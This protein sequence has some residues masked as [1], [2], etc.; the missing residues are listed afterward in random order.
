VIYFPLFFFQLSLLPSFLLTMDPLPITLQDLIESTDALDLDCP[1]LATIAEAP[2]PQRGAFSL[3]GQLI[4]S[5]PLNPLTVW[6]TLQH[7]WKFALPLSFA[8]VGHHKFLFGV[9]LQDYV[10]KIMDQGPWNVRGSLLLLKPWSPDLALDEINLHLCPFWVQA[11]GLPRQNMAAV[12]SVKIAQ[13][14]NSGG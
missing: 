3:I 11:H 10:T 2:Q 8:V 14:K 5:K 12:N 13:R 1:Q 4:A 9:P 6:D 7:A